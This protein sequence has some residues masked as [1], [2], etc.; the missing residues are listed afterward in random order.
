MRVGAGPSPWSPRASS[1]K[2]SK[3]TRKKPAA[4]RTLNVS[5]QMSL[6]AD[7]GKMLS[8]PVLMA[9]SAEAV[10]PSQRS[11]R[12]RQSWG[13]RHRTRP[14]AIAAYASTAASLQLRRPRG[15][16]ASTSW[17]RSS[18]PWKRSSIPRKRN[19]KE[20]TNQKGRSFEPRPLTPARP[21]RVEAPRSH[22]LLPR[23]IGPPSRKK[24]LVRSSGPSANQRADHAKAT[25]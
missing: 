5:S 14:A 13:R 18:C 23:S 7:A 11:C 20:A 12:A 2:A 3:A 9:A 22:T 21:K 25:P 1:V 17:E 8:I 19:P 6:L 16:G 15:T 4:E 24:R 10:I